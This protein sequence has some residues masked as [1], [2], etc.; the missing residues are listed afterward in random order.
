MEEKLKTGH[1]VFIENFYSIY[2]LAQKLL[3]KER[4]CNNSGTFKTNRR[5]TS[6]VSR[7]NR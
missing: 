4:Y 5:N 3:E 2:N 6:Q 1:S 7:R